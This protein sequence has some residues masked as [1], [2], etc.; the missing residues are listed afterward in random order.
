[1][2]NFSYGEQILEKKERKKI[3]NKSMFFEH[4]YESNM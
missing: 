4:Y 1:M 2:A 3:G